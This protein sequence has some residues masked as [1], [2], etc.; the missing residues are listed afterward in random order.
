MNQYRNPYSNFEEQRRLKDILTPSRHRLISARDINT[1]D[2]TTFFLS[3]KWW[4]SHYYYLTIAYLAQ[5]A[6]T[7]RPPS[8]WP[9]R[10]WQLSARPSSPHPVQ[11]NVNQS[12][13][14]AVRESEVVYSSISIRHEATHQ[15]CRRYRGTHV[16]LNLLRETWRYR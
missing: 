15:I 14:I 10:L 12:I 16:S 13:N 11:V 5:A 3:F 7:Y 1:R 2:P 4:S 9:P 8:V 6:S